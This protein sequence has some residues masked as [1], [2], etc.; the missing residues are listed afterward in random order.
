[1]VCKTV[2]NIK[3]V[4]TEGREYTVYLHDTEGETNPAKFSIAYLGFLNSF[5]CIAFRPVCLSLFFFGKETEGSI[6][7]K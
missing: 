5:Y 1:M 3:T 7:V 2:Q 6:I 4:A